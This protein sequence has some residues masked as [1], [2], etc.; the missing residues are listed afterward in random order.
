M[1]VRLRP[2]LVSAKR[3]QAQAVHVSGPG[4]G[5]LEGLNP[6]QAQAAPTSTGPNP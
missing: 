1:D 6:S 5:A 4:G 3:S 2:S